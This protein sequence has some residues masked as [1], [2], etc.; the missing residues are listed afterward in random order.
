MK[1]RSAAAPTEHS[2]W[3]QNELQ[4]SRVTAKAGK[5]MYIYV[6]TSKTGSKSTLENHAKTGVQWLYK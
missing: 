6:N 3:R 1:E 2:K 5:K 4:R